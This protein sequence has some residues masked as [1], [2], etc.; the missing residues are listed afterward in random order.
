MREEWESVPVFA[1]SPGSVACGKLLSL[2]SLVGGV[3]G[4]LP[5]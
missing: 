4:G 2:R 5:L 3:K 1:E